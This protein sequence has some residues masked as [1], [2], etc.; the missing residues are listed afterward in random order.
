MMALWSPQ[1]LEKQTK[2]KPQKNPQK[3][4]LVLFELYKAAEDLA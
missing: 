3:P 2:K 4:T 1:T